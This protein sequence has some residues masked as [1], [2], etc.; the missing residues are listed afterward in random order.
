L[1]SLTNQLNE[2]ITNG[3][4]CDVPAEANPDTEQDAETPPLP[5]HAEVGAALE[6]GL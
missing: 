2:E 5:S 3:T 4:L 1:C 6:I